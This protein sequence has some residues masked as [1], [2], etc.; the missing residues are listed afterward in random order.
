[1]K[2]LQLADGR[3]V[4]AALAPIRCRRYEIIG[5]SQLDIQIQ[6]IL[7]DR[8]GFKRSFGLWIEFDVNINGLLPEPEKQC[9]SAAGQIHLARASGGLRKRLH[10][11][12]KFCSGNPLPHSRRVSR[13]GGISTLRISFL[14]PFFGGNR[15]PW[16]ELPAS[17]Q[18]AR[19]DRRTQSS[20][21]FRAPLSLAP[22]S[23]GFRATQP[24]VS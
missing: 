18:S 1:M 16:L 12:L 3:N 2:E 8:N 6:I 10:E 23:W 21:P 7:K 11:L 13:L 9:S 22:A 17:N 4:L 20:R 24:R 19:K 15:N 14:L 5:R